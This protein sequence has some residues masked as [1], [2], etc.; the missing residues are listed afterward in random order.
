MQNIR[1]NYLL[2]LCSLIL[3]LT[4]CGNESVNN[5]VYTLDIDVSPSEGGSIAEGSADY[6]EG[7]SVTITAIPEDE[8]TFSGWS[9][10]IQA[11]SNPLTFTMDSDKS[12]TANFTK[13]IFSLNVTI[14]G[15][16]TV[17]EKIVQQKMSDYELGTVVHLTPMPNEGW[18]FVEWQED[19]TGD[20]TPAQITI[21]AEKN[22][23]AVFDTSNIY[24]AK[25]G[26]TIMCPEGEIGEI[27]VINGVQYEVVDRDLLV[28]RSR[29]DVVLS[30]LCVSLIKN[31]SG[32]FDGYRFNED[33]TNWDVSNVTTMA[34]M[35][36][37]SQF[38]GNISTWNVD[39]VT[40][41]SNM[42]RESQFNQTIETWNV[43]SVKDMSNM[44]EDSE[45]NQQIGQW[46]VSSVENMNSMFKDSEF[47][48]II[49]DWDVSVVKTMKS[50]FEGVDNVFNQPIGSWDVSSVTDMSHMFFAN[51][52]FNKPLGDWNV[53]NVT[54]MSGMFWAEEGSFN[55][56]IGNWDVSSVT[57]MENMF[58]ATGFNQPIGEWDV[59]NVTNMEEMFWYSQF[60][61][62]IGDWDVSAVSQM[63]GMFQNSPFNHPINTWC[64]DQFE[65]EPAFF[66]DASPLTEENK[67]VWGTCPANKK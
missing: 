10:D 62:P 57:T 17:R 66:S 27:G 16:G 56:P 42:F 32:L 46:D 59:S 31:M 36:R 38:N 5:T 49:D 11:S 65:T 24:L 30:K 54:N 34:D 60:N 40:D 29:E 47:N 25:N 48:Q 1:I 18:R 12:I 7:E 14:L 13:I 58:R 44:F 33:L 22:I 63:E 19:L 39:S 50:M 4:S 3:I 9:G 6:Q 55:Q 35:F 21:D 26:V 51:N 28:Q 2:F 23:T 20:E 15:E 52:V 61:Q 41:M 64:V 45:F 67:P 53:S 8:W 43:G 37:R